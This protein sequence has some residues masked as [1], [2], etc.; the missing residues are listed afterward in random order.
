MNQKE[1][2]TVSREA[3]DK[4]MKYDYPGNIRELENIIEQAVVLC[5]GESISSTDLHIALSGR[6]ADRSDIVGSFE[7]QVCA[8]ETKLITD[9][10][11]KSG[12]IQTRAAALL[13]MSERHLRY[14]MIKY[15]LKN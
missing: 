5:R 11:Q 10:L 6:P 15:Q 12:G 8:F 3:M 2:L 9:A 7:E 13:G 4:L 14:K 1:T